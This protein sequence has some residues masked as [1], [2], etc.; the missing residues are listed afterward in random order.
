[1]ASLSYLWNNRAQYPIGSPAF[2]KA[3]AKRLLLIHHLVKRNHNRWKLVRKGATISGAS[4]IG[5]VKAS[6]NKKNLFVGDFS[7]IGR[8]E[9]S[10]HDEIHIG[11][12]VCINDGALLLTASHNV[13][14][15]LW[16]H[17]KGAII[18]EDYVWVATNAILLPGVKIG[19]GSVIGAGAVV[20]KSV[21]A[22]S[23][24]IGN[25]MVVLPKKRINELVYNPCALL[26]VNNAW[27]NG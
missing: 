15:P 5:T 2:F 27:L 25:P 22:Y 26:A 21:E 3:W 19:T 14:D 8:V 7:T 20:S 18:I 11:K 9:L 24:V 6:G 1:M 4:E 23:I 12:N 17:V 16:R 13:N 10:L